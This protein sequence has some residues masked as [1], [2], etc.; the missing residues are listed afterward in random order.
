MKKVRV[1]HAH[2]GQ[3]H[4][5]GQQPLSASPPQPFPKQE[6]AE[7][8]FSLLL[9]Q[10][11]FT[12]LRKL[13]FLHIFCGGSIKILGIALVEAVNLSLLFNLDIFFHQ[14]KFTKSLER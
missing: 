12:H 3:S 13:L 7:T 2:I 10:A 5:Q 4:K 14:D 11:F 8:V 9:F 1:C 6:P